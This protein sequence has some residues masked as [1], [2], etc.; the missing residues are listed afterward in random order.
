MNI[1]SAIF[2]HGAKSIKK[3]F[4]HIGP[5]TKIILMSTVSINY[6]RSVSGVLLILGFTGK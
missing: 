3:P 6:K 4:H 2:C 5:Y 1:I